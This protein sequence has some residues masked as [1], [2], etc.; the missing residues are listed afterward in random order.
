MGLGIYFSMS[1]GNKYVESF[2]TAFIKFSGYYLQYIDELVYDTILFETTG[3]N[4][5]SVP[6]N[7]STYRKPGFVSFPKGF[8]NVLDTL[9]V[10]STI[11]VLMDYSQGYGINGLRRDSLNYQ[12]VPPYTSLFYTISL[13]DVK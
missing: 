12:I 13:E 3:N 10:G 5:I 6:V 2:D 4:T 1:G 9:L 11:K 7:T 8:S